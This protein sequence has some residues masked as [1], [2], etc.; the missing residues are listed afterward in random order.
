[1]STSVKGISASGY[2]DGYTVY[3]IGLQII[4]LAVV[5]RRD[6]EMYTEQIDTDSGSAKEATLQDFVVEI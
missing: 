2:Y 5:I 1:M 3:G 6:G 4:Y